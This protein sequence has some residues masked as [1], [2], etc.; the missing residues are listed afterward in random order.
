[1]SLAARY[2]TGTNLTILVWTRLSVWR[3][4]AC[5]RSWTNITKGRGR[6][7]RC[8]DNSP[9]AVMALSSK[10]PPQATL[11]GVDGISGQKMWG[12]EYSREGLSERTV[13]QELAQR[14]AAEFPVQPQGGR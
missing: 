5:E 12:K 7:A 6:P 14:V 11:Y 3:R 13:R 2:S 10:Q 9:R 1:M 8:A 4:G